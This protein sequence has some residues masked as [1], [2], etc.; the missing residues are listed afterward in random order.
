MRPLSFALTLTLTLLVAAAAQEPAPP[1][2]IEAITKSAFP[3]AAL[4][5]DKKKLA[6][7]P[8]EKPRAEMNERGQITLYSEAG[9]AVMETSGGRSRFW[10]R[11][12]LVKVRFEKKPPADL[13]TF[14]I[15][16]P[17]GKKISQCYMAYTSDLGKALPDEVR[18]LAFT[19]M[20]FPPRAIGAPLDLGALTR[21]PQSERE[22]VS[23]KGLVLSGLDHEA[24]L[25]PAKDKKKP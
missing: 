25:Q 8:S 13:K 18:L 6:F 16:D 23:F 15:R 21:L 12:L 17:G 3:S 1:W 11:Y 9:G 5:T 10:D 14:S 2:R 7:K 24:P 19:R 20:N 4:Q 22:W